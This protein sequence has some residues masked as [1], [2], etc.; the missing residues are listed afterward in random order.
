MLALAGFLMPRADSILERKKCDM[1]AM[2]ISDFQWGLTNTTIVR[3]L[4]T[5]RRRLWQLRQLCRDAHKASRPSRT[6]TPPA[7]M[8]GRSWTLLPPSCLLVRRGRSLRLRDCC[9][10][11]RRPWSWPPQDRTMPYQRPSIHRV[12]T[13][14]LF[15]GLRRRERF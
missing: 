1:V 5:E 2:T 10:F 13:P 8:Q 7:G 12:C 15:F 6:A 3:A 11:G 4:T 14:P 9:C